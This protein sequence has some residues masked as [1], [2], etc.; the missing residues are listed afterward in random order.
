[1]ISQP[2][3]NKTASAI[4]AT[5]YW[6]YELK[7]FGV[8]VD[9]VMTIKVFNRRVAHYTQV[10]WQRSDR[11][12]CAVNWC[13][14]SSVKMTFAGCQ[15]REAGNNLNG[16][17]YETG[18]SPCTNDTD[19]K[20]NDCKCNATEALCI[21]PDSTPMPTQKYANPQPYHG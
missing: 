10:V 13:T 18:T 1:M 21:R 20:C 5:A 7:R 19:C 2:D 17:I 12:G 4:S 9:N 14:D 3:Y 15:Y 11:I 8:P 16:Y 6:F